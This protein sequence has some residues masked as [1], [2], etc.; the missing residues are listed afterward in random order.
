MLISEFASQGIQH[1]M[2]SFKE[3]VPKGGSIWLSLGD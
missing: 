1:G 3:S 2:H